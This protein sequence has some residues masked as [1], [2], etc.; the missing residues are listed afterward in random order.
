[1]VTDTSAGEAAPVARPLRRDAEQNREAILCAAGRLFADRGAMISLDEVAAEAGVGIATLYRRFPTRE[2][3]IEA[4]VSERMRRY[5]DSAQE[6]ADLAADRPLEAF[7]RYVMLVLEQQVADRAFADVLATPINA[8]SV[9]PDQRRRAFR[10][11]LALVKRA[12]SAGVVRADFDHS[13]LYL[14]TLAND[15]VLRGAGDAAAWK[16]LGAYLFEAF[17]ITTAE[18][19]PGVPRAWSRLTRPT[20][21]SPD[22]D[23]VR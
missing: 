2:S 12:K 19:L 13:D 11:S 23:G 22:P 20:K 6:L 1:M 8:A 17:T 21:A 14:L 7:R 16:R 10:A 5:A 15:G 3:L 18:P 9:C 4:V